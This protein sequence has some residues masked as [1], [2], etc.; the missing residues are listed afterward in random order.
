[1]LTEKINTA[2]IGLERDNYMM[3]AIK[4]KAYDIVLYLLTLPN[5]KFDYQDQNG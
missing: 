4:N 1:M 5:G 3:Y 2:R